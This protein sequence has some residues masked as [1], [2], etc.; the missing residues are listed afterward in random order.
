MSKPDTFVSYIEVDTGQRC[1]CGGRIVEGSA[2]PSPTIS[3]E[4]VV[5]LFGP[6][7][8]NVAKEEDRVSTGY[9][10]NKCFT[11]YHPN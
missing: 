8:P 4:K 10:C 5:P 1:E 2:I 3:P 6:R 9:H 11:L 7:W